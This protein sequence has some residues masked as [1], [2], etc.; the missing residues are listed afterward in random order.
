MAKKLFISYDT[1]ENQKRNLRQKT[2]CK[3][4]AELV[5]NAMKKQFFVNFIFVQ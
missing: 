3:I 2:N 1:V 4:W 5:Y